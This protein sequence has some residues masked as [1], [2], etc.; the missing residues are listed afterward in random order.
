MGPGRVVSWTGAAGVGGGVARWSVW[1]EGGRGAPRAWAGDTTASLAVVEEE[2]GHVVIVR[3]VFAD[4]SVVGVEAA[5][6]AAL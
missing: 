5:G 4:G 2:A 6:R 1:V 3:A